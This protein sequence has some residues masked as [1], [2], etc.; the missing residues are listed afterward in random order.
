M[1]FLGISFNILPVIRSYPRA[2]LGLRSFC[3]YVLD[4]LWCKEFDCGGSFSVLLISVSRY[5]FYG[6]S[7]GLNV[8]SKCPAKIFAFSLSLRAPVWSMFLIG[9]M[10]YVGCFNR[11]VAFQSE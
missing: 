9:G 3:V 11:L 8:F 6:N 10:H 5:S 7:Y 2:Y 4:S 1:P